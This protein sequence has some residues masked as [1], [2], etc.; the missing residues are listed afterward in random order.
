MY[1]VTVINLAVL[2][3]SK[4]TVVCRCMCL[5]VCVCVHVLKNFLKHGNYYIYQI[6]CNYNS[7]KIS[8]HVLT[9]KF[10]QRASL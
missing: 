3:I 6:L 7:C 10:Y 1:S 9:K 8:F 5:C 2:C 4:V